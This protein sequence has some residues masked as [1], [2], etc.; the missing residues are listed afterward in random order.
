M[1]RFPW[2]RLYAASGLVCTLLLLV[3]V[4]LAPIPPVFGATE[5][6]LVSYYQQHSGE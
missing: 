3:S 4:P 6:E 1:R 2:V 5:A